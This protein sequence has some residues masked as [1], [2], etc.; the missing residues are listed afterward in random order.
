MLA[1][2]DKPGW[3]CCLPVCEAGGYC[4]PPGPTILCTDA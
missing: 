4:L 3:R 2:A 1:Y